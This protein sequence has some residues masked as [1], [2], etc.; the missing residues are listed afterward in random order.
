MDDGGS[1]V[2]DETAFVERTVH[3]HIPVK[4]HIFFFEPLTLYL[5]YFYVGMWNLGHLIRASRSI[6]V[7]QVSFR[8]GRLY[9]VALDSRSRSIQA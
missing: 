5:N 2:V 7:G 9:S 8:D 4:R 6:H 3:E 1:S